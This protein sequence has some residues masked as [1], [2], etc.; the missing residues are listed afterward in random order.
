MINM[1]TRYFWALETTK[2]IIKK[3]TKNEFDELTSPPN[4][5]LEFKWKVLVLS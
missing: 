3:K 2:K 5:G 4:A 1:H